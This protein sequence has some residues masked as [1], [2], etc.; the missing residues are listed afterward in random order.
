MELII[1]HAQTVTTILF[2][3]L[4][5]LPAK[6][7]SSSLNTDTS[8]LWGGGAFEV[9]VGGVADT[10]RGSGMGYGIMKYTSHPRGASLHLSWGSQIAQ[11]TEPPYFTQQDPHPHCA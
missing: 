6:K 4:L 10:T 5:L 3:D 7:K 9:G 11:V 8:L 2:V 1:D